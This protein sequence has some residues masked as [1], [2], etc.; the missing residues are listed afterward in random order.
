LKH[1]ASRDTKSDATK[2]SLAWKNRWDGVSFSRENCLKPESL[3]FDPIDTIIHSNLGRWVALAWLGDLFRPPKEI[4]FGTHLAT[5]LYCNHGEEIQGINLC[6]LVKS[7]DGRFFKSCDPGVGIEV[8]WLFKLSTLKQFEITEM[9]QAEIAALNLPSVESPLIAKVDEKIRRFRARRALDLFRHPAFP[10]DLLVEI[11]GKLLE[12]PR[13][14]N[15]SG[16]FVWFRVQ[17]IIG[18]NEFSSEL[19]NQPHHCDRKKGEVISAELVHSQDS[20]RLVAK[21]S[22]PHPRKPLTTKCV[23]P[24]L[25]NK[26]TERAE[27]PIGLY[28]IL[29]ETLGRRLQRDYPQLL[30]AK[31]WESFV[32]MGTLVGCFTLAMALHFE[33]AEDLRTELEM[34]MRNRLELRWPGAEVFFEDLGR[35]VSDSLLAAQWLITHVAGGETLVNEEKIVGEIAEILLNECSGFWKSVQDYSGN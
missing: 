30:L 28:R 6:W 3:K 31:H 34:I 9:A 19:L 1:R 14:H 16:E 24:E 29:F 7:P 22:N 13:A 27:E 23:S 18:E 26:L 8:T 15:L 20:L 11:T 35:F 21:D 4:P 12:K 10:D 2:R 5:F 32:G 17:A 33:V 25:V